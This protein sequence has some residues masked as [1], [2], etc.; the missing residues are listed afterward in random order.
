M[1]KMIICLLYLASFNVFGE[2]FEKRIYTG[3]GKFL[4]YKIVDSEPLRV[5]F[6]EFDSDRRLINLLAIPDNNERMENID[7]YRLCNPLNLERNLKKLDRVKGRIY[8]FSAFEGILDDVKETRSVL[9]KIK[10]DTSLAEIVKKK[11]VRKLR[12]KL[13][14]LYVA[15]PLSTIVEILPFQVGINITESYFDNYNHRWVVRNKNKMRKKNRKIFDELE[16]RDQILVTNKRYQNLKG[17]IYA[18]CY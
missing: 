6:Y 7:Q 17:L 3:D 18:N 13:M 16:S 12:S 5:Q 9:E 14:G 15:L 1:N 11:Q 2:D 8:R 4:T 10:G